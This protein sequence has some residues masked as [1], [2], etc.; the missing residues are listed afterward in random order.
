MIASKMNLTDKD[1]YAIYELRNQTD[2]ILKDHEKIF[3]VL[4]KAESDVNRVDNIVIK[5]VFKKKEFV[6]SFTS[7][8]VDVTKLDAVE[9][10]KLLDL[11]FHQAITDVNSGKIP[12]TVEETVKLA[13][14]NAFTIYGKYDAKKHV[15]GY[16]RDS[17][18]RFIP[19]YQPRINKG[20]DW[21]TEFMAEYKIVKVSTATEAKEAYLAILKKWPY[22]GCSRV[23]VRNRTPTMPPAL[24]LSVNKDGLHIFRENEKEPFLKYEFSQLLS[25]NGSPTCFIMTSGDLRKNKKFFFETTQ[26]HDISK[27]LNQFV[28]KMIHNK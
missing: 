2:A 1:S 25:W 12:V 3:D 27:L 17:L 18:P 11:E 4:A 23:F 5:Y 26:G 19:D 20:V 6:A 24:W 9:V 8:D 22:Y 14:L 10:V 21:D 15:P 28:D 13:A 7:N 16:F